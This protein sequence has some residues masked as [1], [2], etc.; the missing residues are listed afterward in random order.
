MA[1]RE[2]REEGIAVSRKPGFLTATQPPGAPPRVTVSGDRRHRP[3]SGERKRERRASHE[4]HDDSH[5]HRGDRRDYREPEWRGS[6]R[7]AR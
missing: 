5:E 7:R 1:N 2:L 4:V 3:E 6:F